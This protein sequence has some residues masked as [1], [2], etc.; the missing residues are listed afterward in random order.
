MSVEDT[1]K[2]FDSQYLLIQI[3]IIAI[4][5]EEQPREDCQIPKVGNIHDNKKEN[6]KVELRIIHDID[7]R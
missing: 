1:Y 7:H 3:E 2:N 6:R 4:E 5:A